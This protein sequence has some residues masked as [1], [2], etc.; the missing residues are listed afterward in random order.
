MSAYLFI[1]QGSASSK[2]VATLC[3]IQVRQAAHRLSC[4]ATWQQLEILIDTE[5][6][7]VWHAPALF[8]SHLSSS[9]ATRKHADVNAPQA[10]A[11]A[12]S[13]LQK[14]YPGGQCIPLGQSW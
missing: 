5:A 7:Q 12:H 3:C 6:R 9:F 2:N 14:A 10:K 4:R 8:V 13:D 11:V 1:A